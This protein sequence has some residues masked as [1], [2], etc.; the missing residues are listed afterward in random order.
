[1]T[2]KS[3]V[4][5]NKSEIVLK[6]EHQHLLLRQVIS[7]LREFRTDVLRQIPTLTPPFYAQ[8]RTFSSIRQINSAKPV[9][10]RRSS[11]LVLAADKNDTEPDTGRRR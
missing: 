8:N 7:G 4:S 10:I 9:S 2:P 1:M 5:L 6:K 3:T 11:V